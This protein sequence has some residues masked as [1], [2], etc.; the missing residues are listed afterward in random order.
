MDVDVEVDMS[1]VSQHPLAHNQIHQELRRLQEKQDK[2]WQIDRGH[3]IM[4]KLYQIYF[5]KLITRL[6]DIFVWPVQ[7]QPISMDQT[8]SGRS[9]L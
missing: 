8:M 5:I 3:L 2:L 4:L 1:D 6:R 9:L 7:H